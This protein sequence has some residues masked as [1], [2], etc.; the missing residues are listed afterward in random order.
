MEDVQQD[1]ISVDERKT[2]QKRTRERE[3]IRN[4]TRDIKDKKGRER[5]TR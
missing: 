1:S 4:Y 5:D 3:R 2:K